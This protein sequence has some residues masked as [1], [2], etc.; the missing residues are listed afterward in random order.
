MRWY[1]TMEIAFD[2]FIFLF[3]IV[4]FGSFLFIIIGIIKT[5]KAGREIKYNV[6]QAVKSQLKSHSANTV[7]KEAEKNTHASQV[8]YS[9]YYSQ[10]PIKDSGVLI[11]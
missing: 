9:Q 4:F 6:S 8:A 11:G 10:K 3:N 5:S 7:G 1:V 2:V